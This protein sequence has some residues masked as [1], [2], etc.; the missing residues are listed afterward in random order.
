MHMTTTKHPGGR[1]TKYLPIYAE[2]ARK[3]AEFG[4]TDLEVAD[5]FDI[6][7][8]TLYLWKNVHPEFS[9]ALKVGKEE[10]DD[11][12]ER[13]LYNKAVGYSYES[14]KIFQ[15]QGEVIRAK[16]REHVPPSEAAMIFWLKNRRPDTWRDKVVQEHQGGFG[17]VGRLEIEIIN[18]ELPP[19]EPTQAEAQ[20]DPE[21]GATPA[22]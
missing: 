14:E 17:A 22:A 21:P 13:S 12:V 9:E 2:Q 8:S 1:P 5:F 7:S 3:L 6:T 10:A 20:P 11:R 15:F 16:T 19:D 4:A 18:P